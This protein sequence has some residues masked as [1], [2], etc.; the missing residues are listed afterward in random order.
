VDSVGPR[1]RT[2]ALRQLDDAPD[3]RGRADGVRGDR[4]R[5]HPGA[6]GHLRLEILV[7]Q[8]EV[9]RHGRDLDDDPE[10]VCELEPRGDVCIVVE[11]GHDDLV[12]L[13]QRARERPAEQEVESR[14]ALAERDLA[15][16]A[17]EETA[18]G[19]VGVFDELRRATTRLVRCSDVGVVLSEVTR[20][21]VDDPVR[22]LRPARPVEEGEV[23]VK[24]R[25]TRT[26]RGNVENSGAHMTSSPLTIQ[27]CR[28]LALSEFETKHPC[29]ALASRPRSP[30]S[31]SIGVTWTSS[32]VSISTNAWRPS[33]S[34]FVTTPWALPELATVTPARLA[35]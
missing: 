6:V 1:E 2:D 34:R 14:H 20:D 24:R 31:S 32:V 11:G 35:E 33:S 26:D 21:R 30:S 9:R 3:V 17:A 22:A 13:T 18:R 7:V 16:R 27:R 4:E 10:V 29:S 12:A 15:G 5:E 23:S 8:L 25:E 19:L 28:G